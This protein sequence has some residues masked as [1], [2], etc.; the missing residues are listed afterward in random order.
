MLDF[1]SA[2]LIVAL[3]YVY[4]VG[5]VLIFLNWL[6]TRCLARGHSGVS[7]AMA[8]VVVSLLLL[9]PVKSP[10]AGFLF[11]DSY[12][13]WSCIGLVGMCLVSVV[14]TL[15]SFSNQQKQ[16]EDTNTTAKT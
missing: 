4:W 7:I 2:I 1:S 16:S 13:P 3:L 11:R 6:L 10:G 12:G 14:T 5:P 9:G 15:V 8:N